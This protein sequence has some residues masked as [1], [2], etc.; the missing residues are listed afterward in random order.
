MLGMYFIASCIQRGEGMGPGAVRD[1]GPCI[2]SRKLGMF[3]R[4]LVV[5]LGS[6]ASAFWEALSCSRYL[7]CRTLQCITTVSPAARSM[8]Y[9]EKH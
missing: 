5:L 7:S 4:T 6:A 2:S 8:A 9:D 1:M 3:E